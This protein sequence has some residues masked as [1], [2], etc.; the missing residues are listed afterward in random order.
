MVDIGLPS[1]V[2]MN[3]F[4]NAVNYTETITGHTGKPRKALTYEVEKIEDFPAAGQQGLKLNVFATGTPLGKAECQQIFTEGYRSGNSADI[5]GSVHGGE[6]GCE[7]T[8]EGNNFYFIL[9]LTV[10]IPENNHFNEPYD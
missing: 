10:G 5:S 4:S 3:L 8:E 6:S 2:Y 7:P 9:P 1:Q